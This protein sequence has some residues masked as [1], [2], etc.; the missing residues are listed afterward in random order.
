MRRI[1]DV[2]PGLIKW[3][4]FSEYLLDRERKK[5]K[6]WGTEGPQKYLAS[7]ALQNPGIKTKMVFA[8]KPS[9]LRTGLVIK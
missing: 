6:K 4:Q 1:R 9:S 2:K 7:S 5:R 8:L 3:G